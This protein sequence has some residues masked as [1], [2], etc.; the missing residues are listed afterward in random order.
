[1][2]NQLSRK[3]EDLNFHYQQNKE[4]I[5]QYQKELQDWNEQIITLQRNIERTVSLIDELEKQNEDIQQQIDRYYEI[6][7]NELTNQKNQLEN[8]IKRIRNKR[9]KYKYTPYY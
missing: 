6:I 3:I 5:S 8:Q 9:E 4:K 1:M 2:D 7:E